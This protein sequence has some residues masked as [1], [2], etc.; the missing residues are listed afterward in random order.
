MVTFIILLGALGN[1]TQLLEYPWIGPPTISDPYISPLHVQSEQEGSNISYYVVFNVEYTIKPAY[2][3]ISKDTELVIPG[4]NDVMWD[5]HHLQKKPQIEVHIPQDKQFVSSNELNGRI[6]ITVRSNF[7]TEPIKQSIIVRENVGSRE[8]DKIPWKSNTI[9]PEL[10]VSIDSD[11]FGQLGYI[12]Y[13]NLKYSLYEL[14]IKNTGDLKFENY[15]YWDP[16]WEIYCYNYENLDLD[17]Y[18]GDEGYISLELAHNETKHVLA[19]KKL[20]DAHPL[21]TGDNI[22]NITS[23]TI[24]FGA[25]E[26]YLELTE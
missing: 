2:F 13:K 5:T 10:L 21:G 26:E 14:R 20:S 24:C 6:P 11:Y 25:W 12:T 19:L 7:G 23:E 15:I 16:D 1:S 3:P 17:R 9:K 18:D 4:G 8:G 22:F